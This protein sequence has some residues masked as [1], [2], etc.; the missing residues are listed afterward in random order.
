MYILNL[1]SYPI[2]CYRRKSFM[3]SEKSNGNQT[4]YYIKNFV[5][6][7]DISILGIDITINPYTKEIYFNLQYFSCIKY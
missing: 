5:Q 7:C 3:Y 6:N 1:F 2:C 4:V